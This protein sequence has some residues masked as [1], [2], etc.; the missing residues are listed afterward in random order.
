MHSTLPSSLAR[1]MK[2]SRATSKNG[3]FIALGTMTKWY[4][5]WARAG[6][7][8]ISIAMPAKRIFLIGL[9]L[10]AFYAYPE[11]VLFR[12]VDRRDFVGLPASI[13]QFMRERMRSTST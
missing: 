9:L 5:V 11:N 4:L 7:A 6:L 1:F 12:E 3:L 2:P 8:I 10:H 13:P